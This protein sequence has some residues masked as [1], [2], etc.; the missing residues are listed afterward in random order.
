MPPLMEYRADQDLIGH[1]VFN[2]PTEKMNVMSAQFMEE[3][4]DILGR[5]DRDEKVR[6]V[7][8]ES[9]KPGVFVAGADIKWLLDLKTRRTAGISRRRP[10]SPSTASR[11]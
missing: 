5:I 7:V 9:G 2:H 4:L 11:P 3:L 6:G 8:L 1:I 10:T